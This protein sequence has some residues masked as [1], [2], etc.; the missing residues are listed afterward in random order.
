MLGAV[1][2][3]FPGRRAKPRAHRLPEGTRVY[4][5]GDVH[6]CLDE[7]NRL[8]DAIEKD[9]LGRNVRA[10]LIFLGDLVDRGPN[11][12]G[13]IERVLQGR[14]PGDDSLFLMGNHE[15]AMLACA[16]GDTGTYGKWLQYGG[17]QTLESYGITEREVFGRR[18]DLARAMRDAIPAAHIRFIRS[19]QDHMTVGDYVFVHAGIRPGRSLPEQASGDLRWIRADFLNSQADHGFVVVHGHTIVQR[20]EQHGNRI[21]VDTGCYLSGRLSAVVMEGSAVEVLSTKE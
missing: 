11:S 4:A 19:F 9:L 6:G 8:L 14:L 20:V 3:R 18:F 7:L 5:I 17:L 13:V 12:A 16:D 10:Q 2:R 21:A 1:L 15:E